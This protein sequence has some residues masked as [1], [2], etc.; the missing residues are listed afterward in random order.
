MEIADLL[1]VDMQSLLVRQ[2]KKEEKR[3]KL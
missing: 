3:L 2:D 1:G